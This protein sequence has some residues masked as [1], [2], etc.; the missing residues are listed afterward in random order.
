MLFFGITLVRRF[1]TSSRPGCVIGW[2]IILSGISTSF[3]LITK[4]LPALAPVQLVF[5]VFL[6]VSLFVTYLLFR[7]EMEIRKRNE[8]E[9]LYDSVSKNI[10]NVA[11]LRFAENGSKIYAN[12]LATK[13]IEEVTDL[14]EFEEIFKEPEKLRS[15][16]ADALRTMK[17]SFL[18]VEIGQKEFVCYIYPGKFSGENIIDIV[19]L[20]SPELKAIE[21]KLKNEIEEFCNKVAAEFLVPAKDFLDLCL[22]KLV[23]NHCLVLEGLLLDSYGNL[24]LKEGYQKKQYTIQLL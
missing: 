6:V 9:I 10:S 19:L 2:V 14:Y 20:D 18:N 11:M 24:I 23:L 8:L 12:P 22:D 16:I 3:S 13:F 5:N 4:L 7:I 21:N 1:T 17:V 15:R